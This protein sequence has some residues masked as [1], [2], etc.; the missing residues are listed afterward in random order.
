[1]EQQSIHPGVVGGKRRFPLGGT[2]KPHK[3]KGK[4]A[5]KQKELNRRQTAW[6]ST[7]K[8]AGV[9]AAAFKMPGSLKGRA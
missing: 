6:N 5:R 7:T 4:L 3:G 1:M 2:T 9:D 8:S